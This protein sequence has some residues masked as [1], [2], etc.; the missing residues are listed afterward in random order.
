MS[1]TG[2]LLTEHLVRLLAELDAIDCADGIR[3]RID[4][5]DSQV[6]RAA[7]WLA[8]SYGFLFKNMDAEDWLREAGEL[9]EALR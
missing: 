5:E 7:A 8:H 9:I 6:M 4:R 2:T 3:E 1:A